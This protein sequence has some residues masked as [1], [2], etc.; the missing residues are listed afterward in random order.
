MGTVVRYDEAKLRVGVQFPHPTGIVSI[1]AANL[2]IKARERDRKLQEE[3]ARRKR[4][5]YAEGR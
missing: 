5:E 3:H 2:E 1:R 4:E